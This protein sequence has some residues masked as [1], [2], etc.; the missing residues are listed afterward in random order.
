MRSKASIRYP[1]GRIDDEAISASRGF[2]PEVVRKAI[3]RDTSADAIG[4]RG[5]EDRGTL[6]VAI[7]NR[8]RDQRTGVFDLDWRGVRYIRNVLNDDG[9]PSH[10]CSSM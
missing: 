4:D 9:G 1:G 6:M 3:R 10:R 5:A 2:A 7:P 8:G